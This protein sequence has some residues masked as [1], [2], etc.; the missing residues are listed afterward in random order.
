M[1]RSC[2]IAPRR[3]RVSGPLW[4]MDR[5][6]ERGVA[7]GIVPPAGPEVDRTAACSRPDCRC[8]HL[9]QVPRGRGNQ[10]SN[11]RCSSGLAGCLHGPA[12]PEWRH[13]QA[14]DRLDSRKVSAMSATYWC[15]RDVPRTTC[16]ALPWGW[17]MPSSW[18]ITRPCGRCP[19]P[20]VE[21]AGVLP[22]PRANDLAGVNWPACAAIPPRWVPLSGRSS[23][24]FPEECGSGNAAVPEPLPRKGAHPSVAPV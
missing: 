6:S 14:T 17:T 3:E 21:T 4:A 9:G 12:R 13:Q 23:V 19:K 8:R 24:P 7:P 20:T 11:R 10:P 15:F 16:G 18:P 2:E 22:E 5:G 1:L